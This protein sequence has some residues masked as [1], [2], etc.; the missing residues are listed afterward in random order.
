M[1]KVRTIFGLAILILWL[2]LLLI[3]IFNNDEL[4]LILFLSLTVIIFPFLISFFKSFSPPNA[5]EKIEF[6]FQSFIE[7]LSHISAFGVFLALI[8]SGL[9]I[10]VNQIYTYLKLGE[11][12]PYSIVDSFKSVGL[13][14]ASTPN[15]WIGLWEVLN[16]MPLSLV[17]IILSLVVFEQS[18]KK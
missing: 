9:G 7:K 3:S 14:W 18:L 17:L 1:S 11:W 15:D 5:T 10:F 12:Q 4:F 2:S 6:L 16:F 8:F 13:K